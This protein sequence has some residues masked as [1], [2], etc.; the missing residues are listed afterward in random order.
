MLCSLS[1][2]DGISCNIVLGYL[3]TISLLLK[4][5][6]KFEGWKTVQR[7][8]YNERFALK[9]VFG[10]HSKNSLDLQS[11]GWA[12]E[13][14]SGELLCRKDCSDGLLLV[15]QYTFQDQIIQEK[16]NRQ[17]FQKEMN[18]TVIF[19]KSQNTQKFVVG[20]ELPV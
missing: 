18:I 5:V 14:S 6:I 12:L 17:I 20:E 9:K 11:K 13:D 2:E 1:D 8:M 10:V 7:V 15:S 4:M 16:K 19:G 3:E